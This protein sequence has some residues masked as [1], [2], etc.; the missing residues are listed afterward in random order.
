MLNVHALRDK[1]SGRTKLYVATSAD[2]YTNTRGFILD[3]VYHTGCSDNNEF[4][5]SDIYTARHNA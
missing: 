1:A 4:P 2:A 5:H 3:T